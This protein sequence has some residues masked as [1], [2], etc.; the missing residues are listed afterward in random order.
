MEEARAPACRSG[1][2]YAVFW[3]LLGA[4]VDLSYTSTLAHMPSEMQAKQPG[5]I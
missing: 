1:I 3:S 2:W 4:L 5:V